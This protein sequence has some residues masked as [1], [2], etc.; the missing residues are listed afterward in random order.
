[1]VLQIPERCYCMDVMYPVAVVGTAA[2]HLLVYSL[3]NQP[4]FFKKIENPLKYQHRCVSIFKDKSQR[5]TGFALG[6]IE[7]RVAIQ[8][9]NP[10]NPTKDNFTFKCH[11]SV[12]TG[13]GQTQDIFAVND[14]AFHPVHGTL[15]T[16]G[17]DG[18]YYFWDKDA[19]TK[20]KHSEA[21]E[22]PITSCCFNNSGAVFAYSV[23]YDWSKGHEHYSPAKKNYIFL[24]QA[25]EDL[26]PRKKK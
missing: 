9:L 6:S 17:S 7:G 19:R 22:Q 8:Y 21:L 14:I 16:V 13:A 15:S 24:R 3:E 23:S 5:P 1:M 25:S 11:R 12:V 20:L 4:Q 10:M 18:R 2:R 26:K